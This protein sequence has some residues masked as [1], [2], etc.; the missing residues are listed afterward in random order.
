MKQGDKESRDSALKGL[1][2]AL[3]LLI[4]VPIPG[5]REWEPRHAV[6][7]LPAVG[8]LIGVGGAALAVLLGWVLP[9]AVTAVLIVTFLTFISGCLHLDGLADTADGLMGTDDP[10][11]A[12][13]IMRDSRIGSM[14]VAAVVCVLAVKAAALFALGPGGLW[15]GA[16][17][18]P[19]AGRVGIVLAAWF[20]PY[21]RTEGGL[22]AEFCETSGRWETLLPVLLL[23][24][25]LPLTAGHRGM[26]AAAVSVGGTI[27]F[28]M[29]QNRQLGGA[30]GDT[31]GATCEVA[32]ACAAIGLCIT[33]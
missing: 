21:A 10:E 24:I 25:V 1:L 7:W 33:L 9:V 2:T 13:A 20:L 15:R 28:I 6:R 19:L 17:A 3:R 11:E 31:L 18:L 23:A 8:L 29:L 30:T 22:G 12:M 16:L 27:G 32:E 14:G 5:P 4:A 26:M